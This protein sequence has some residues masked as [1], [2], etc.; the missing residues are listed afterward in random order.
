M[1]ETDLETASESLSEAIIYC[2]NHCSRLGC[3]VSPSIRSSLPC[4][5]FSDSLFHNSDKKTGKVLRVCPAGTA[6]RCSLRQQELATFQPARILSEV[7][8]PVKTYKHLVRII[9]FLSPFHLAATVFISW[10]S[11]LVNCRSFEPL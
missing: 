9:R 7:N 4:F 3:F 2:R 11:C 10:A 8:E 5:P 6:C 1:L